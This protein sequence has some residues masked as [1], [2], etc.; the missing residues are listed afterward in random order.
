M[1]PVGPAHVFAGM[2]LCGCGEV[3]AIDFVD[4]PG[5]PFIIALSRPVDTVEELD[6]TQQGAVFPFI[7]WIAGSSQDFGL[8]KGALQS[9]PCIVGG[10]G[11][12][13]EST[14]TTHFFAQSAVDAVAIFGSAGRVNAHGV[15]RIRLPAQVTVVTKATVCGNIA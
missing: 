14:T 1:R 9:F 10:S 4:H 2:C 6:G 11:R 15:A 12:P 5:H 13:A 3:G 7:D 8:Y